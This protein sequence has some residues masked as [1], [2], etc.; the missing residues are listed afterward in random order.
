MC[1][2]IPALSVAVDGGRG[3]VAYVFNYWLTSVGAVQVGSVGTP[4]VNACMFWLNIQCFGCWAHDNF[5]PSGYRYTIFMDCL[6]RIPSRAIG[7][8]TYRVDNIIESFIANVLCLDTGATPLSHIIPIRSSIDGMIAS[9][10]NNRSLSSSGDPR[11]RC[12]TTY[13]RNIVTWIQFPIHWFIHLHS[14]RDR[15]WID[16]HQHPDWTG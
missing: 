15:A 5:Q 13:H 1:C 11:V 9:P 7:L 14:K 12:F 4:I 6:D 10:I 16:H 3:F 2:R 8:D